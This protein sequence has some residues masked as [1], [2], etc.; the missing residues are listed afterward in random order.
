MNIPEKLSW[1][2]TLDELTIT[3]NTLS[4]IDKYHKDIENFKKAIQ[5]K[6]EGLIYLFSWLDEMS[7]DGYG[8]DYEWHAVY[9]KIWENLIYL[10]DYSHNILRDEN[11]VLNYLISNNI[12]TV[13]TWN[14]DKEFWWVDAKYIVWVLKDEEK[15]KDE[16]WNIIE[17]DTHLITRG[18]LD[19]WMIEFLRSNDI[20]VNEVELLEK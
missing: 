10:M 17:P 3:V 8:W 13:Y 7:E 18:K 5:L 4:T 11:I 12:K 15:E 19:D 6:S 16:D 20:E 1:N 9:Q 14:I 2:H